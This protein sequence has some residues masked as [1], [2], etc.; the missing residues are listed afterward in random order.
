MVGHDRPVSA[1]AGPLTQDQHDRLR[2]IED[3][4]QYNKL[5][6]KLLLEAPL[7]IHFDAPQQTYGFLFGGIG[8]ARHLFVSLA[9]IG[10]LCPAP[11][12]KRFHFTMV[13]IKTT[14]LAR[15]LVMLYIFKLLSQFSMEQM[16]H[17]ISA[18][19]VI[20]SFFFWL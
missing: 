11:T 17:D 18:I 7:R 8:D 10:C 5:Y 20:S 3:K 19:E 14:A 13:D 4:E 9:D 1:F 12:T 6:N 15:D 16:Q 2:D